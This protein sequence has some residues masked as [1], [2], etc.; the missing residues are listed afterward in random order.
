MASPNKEEQLRR[1]LYE[2]QLMEN[3]VQILQQRFQILTSASSDLQISQQTLQDMKDLPNNNPILI[4]IGG[5]TFV[6]GKTGDLSTV[7][8][9]IGADIS[10]EMKIEDAIKEINNRLEEVTK[11]KTSVEEQLSQILQQMEIYQNVANRL[12]AELQGA[13]Q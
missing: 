8:V 12:S 10:V 11:A 4:P 13:S 1:I 5:G 2:Y 6:Q 7:V 9:G 3:S